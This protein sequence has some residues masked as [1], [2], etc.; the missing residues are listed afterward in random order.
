MYGNRG[1]RGSGRGGFHDL[2]PPVKVGDEFD[3]RIEAVGEKGDGIAKK[4]N[5]VIFVP[6][7]KEGDTIRVRVTKVLR[8]VGFGEKIGDAQGPVEQSQPSSRPAPSQE[9]RMD[10]PAEA[11]PAPEDSENFGEEQPEELGDDS[12]A[13]YEEER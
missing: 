12:E 7:V 2:T 4:Q 9:E 8:K 6:G 3:V 1:N 5:F 10:E 11:E 13:S